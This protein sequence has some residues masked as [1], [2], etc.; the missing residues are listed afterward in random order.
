MIPRSPFPLPVSPFPLLK[1]ALPWNEHLFSANQRPKVAINQDRFGWSTK[2]ADQRLK[3]TRT[4]CV[5]IR[6]WFVYC[7]EL[8][9]KGI[10]YC[11]WMEDYFRTFLQ[12]WKFKAER[13]CVYTV[14]WI[15][16]CRSFKA[17]AGWDR[18]TG[19]SS[20]NV[21]YKLISRPLQ[22]KVNI[23]MF[24]WKGEMQWLFTYAWI[25]GNITNL[26]LY[27]TKDIRTNICR[28]EIVGLFTS[29]VI[30]LIY[31]VIVLQVAKESKTEIN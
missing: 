13:T 12:T 8:H 21:I 7:V 31:I 6:I 14:A 5:W 15:L 30:P 22:L 20:F 27:G 2:N 3:L 29:G 1:I 18:M 9:A 26:H 23:Y 19:T 28:L 24:S 25:E 17:D 10:C 16:F 4:G 11:L